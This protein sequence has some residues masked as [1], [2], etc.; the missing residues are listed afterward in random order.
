[1]LTRLLTKR[2]RHCSV[3]LRG[4]YVDSPCAIG[5]RKLTRLWV[6]LTQ[7]PY[8]TTPSTHIKVGFRRCPDERHINW[9]EC[10]DIELAQVL[11]CFQHGKICSMLCSVLLGTGIGKVI[12]FEY[13][14]PGS[15]QTA[16]SA[17]KALPKTRSAHSSVLVIDL[18]WI[19]A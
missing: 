1:M 19:A 7:A 15:H 14:I 6:S 17:T 16:A 8:D 4:A 13:W 18:N 5:L 11:V 2:L 12:L 10:S 3:Q 9:Q